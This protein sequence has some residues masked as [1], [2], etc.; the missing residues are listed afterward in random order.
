MK[1]LPTRHNHDKRYYPPNQPEPQKP[2][3]PEHIRIDD[4]RVTQ[5]GNWRVFSKHRD[6]AQ[7]LMIPE[8]KAIILQATREIDRYTIDIQQVKA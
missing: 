6:Y 4:A 2:D 8:I 1:E 5:N 3:I 7:M